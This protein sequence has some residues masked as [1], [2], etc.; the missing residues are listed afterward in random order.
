M[1]AIS[2]AQI[3]MGEKKKHDLELGDN[4]QY[5]AYYDIV[6]GKYIVYKKIGSIQIGQ[7]VYMTVDEYSKF[8][9]DKKIKDYY[10]E[11]SSSKDKLARGE[12]SDDVLGKLLSPIQI[13]SKLFEIIF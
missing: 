7:P 5:E 1:G 12:K 2:F 11:K 4:A 10:K 3:D 9:L 13:K 8:I 6:T